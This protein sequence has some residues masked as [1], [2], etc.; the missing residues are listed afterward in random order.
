MLSLAS[1]RMYGQFDTSTRYQKEQM[2]AKSA[3]LYPETSIEITTKGCRDP[4][5]PLVCA[6]KVIVWPRQEVRNSEYQESPTLHR[7]PTNLTE[8][9]PI[10]SLRP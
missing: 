4:F 7:T 9:L 3:E 5:C 1:N 10:S 6:V 2:I 8:A